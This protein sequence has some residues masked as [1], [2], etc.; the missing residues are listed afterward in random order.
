[1]IIKGASVYTENGTFE[2]KTIEVTGSIFSDI[3]ESGIADQIDNDN[4]DID[5]TGCYAI[6]G[7]LDLHFH[8]CMGVDFCDGNIESVRKIA[9]YEASQGVTSII[10]A[11]MTYDEE[12]LIKIAET[13]KKF[14]DDSQKHRSKNINVKNSSDK[15]ATSDQYEKCATLYGINME[16][17]FVSR[18]KCGAQN[19]QYIHKP[20]YEMF[21]RINNAC[22]NKVKLVDIAPETDGAMEFIKKASRETRISLAHTTADYDTAV[23]AFE[24]GVR[25]MTHLFNAMPGLHHRNPGPIPA[26]ADREDVTAEIICDNVH[27]TPVMVR[28]AFKL[29]GPDRLIFISDTMEAA[30][31]EDGEYQ[32]GGQPVTVRGKLATLHDGTIA[33]SVTNLMKC[34]RTAVLEMGIPLTDAIRCAT[35]NPAK[36]MGLYDEIG[37]ITS[38][39]KADMV[40]LDKKDLSVRGVLVRGHLL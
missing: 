18:E 5:A 3:R 29:F 36:A 2:D 25:H 17:P 21:Q 40:L 26:G 35:M 13:A 33:G 12:R 9:E 23:K 8:G 6:P 14:M 30:G 15:T 10:P 39:K 24:N 1:M 20:D 27:I 11:T 7:L 19:P 28:M 32:L 38:G 34:M 22:D 31:L 4:S 37:S 16:G